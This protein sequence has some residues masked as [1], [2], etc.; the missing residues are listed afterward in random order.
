MNSQGKTCQKCGRPI[1][2]TI[3]PSCALQDAFDEGEAEGAA[4]GAPD[5][6][7]TTAAEAES[8]VGSGSSA[9]EE[10]GE[11]SAYGPYRAI[12][13][14]GEGGFG[15][16]YL[17]LQTAPIRRHVALKVLK[18]GMAD[19]QRL[20]DRFELERQALARMDH[21]SIC[22]VFDAGESAAGQ[23][24][25]AME[26]VDGEAINTYCAKKHLPISELLRL[27]Q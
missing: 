15:I 3:C 7:V 11:E 9:G 20:L 23:P 2:G 1:T 24:Y 16:V 13:T 6:A 4:P 17:A 26:L 12:K 19:S 25:F 14:L 22:R 18:R 10:R 21:P 27:D 8:D 5:G